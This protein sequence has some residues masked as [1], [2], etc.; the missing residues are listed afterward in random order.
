MNRASL[1][2]STRSGALHRLL[3]PGN[4]TIRVRLS[5]SA[6]Q[7][8][9]K[10]LNSTQSGYKVLE[11]KRRQGQKLDATAITQMIQWLRFIGYSVD[12]SI[13]PSD[14]NRMNIIHV[15]GTKGKG[16]T[17]AYTNS[18]LQRFQD[19]VHVPRKIGL[20]TSPHLVAVRERIRINSEPISEE[21][22][23]KYF[24]EVW[25]GLEASASK[26]GLDPGHKPS[27][28]RFLTLMSFHVFMRENVDAAIYEV[29]VGGEYDSTNIVDKPAAVAI[30]TLG[31]DHVQSLGETIDLIAWHKAGIM[32]TGSPAVTTE[33][34][35][36]AMEVLEK[37]AEEKGVRLSK[38]IPS[39]AL[40]R[41]SLLPAQ[42]FQRKNAS[43]AVELAYTVLDKLNVPVKRSDDSLPTQFVEGL[44]TLVWRGRCET[45]VTGKQHWYMDGAHNEQSLEVACQWFGSVT[46]ASNRPRVL[47]FNQQS[48]RESHQ[49]L[50]GIH[51]TIYKD[52]QTN[53]QYAI[54]CTNITY[55][56]QSWNVD[57]A[58]HNVD[59][60]ELKS[61]KL[62]HEMAETW[63]RLD[64][65]AEAVAVPTI[66]DAIEFIR[67]LDG[68]ES[69]IDV[70]VTGSFHLVGGALTLLEGKGFA[71]K[72]ISSIL[73]S[74][75]A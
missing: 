25:N 53:F 57:H 67:K 2:A 59:P 20:Y 13:Q 49:L 60:A 42:D 35:P 18:I 17:C 6:Y 31:I 9:V 63:R 48:T 8:A 69:E 28:F 38:V 71:L 61:M 37:R 3:Q 73:Q 62:Q 33:Q 36:E 64:P 47:I 65:S 30:T 74:D 40:K 7:D 55:K 56:D 34:I 50:E 15:A 46:K 70:L 54:F 52:C 72:R 24:F 51:Q 32:K 66:E 1:R 26:E 41:V 22:F 11:E 43:L 19:T 23:A 5:T 39:P 21:L 27:Y 14:L 4:M 45:K 44:E 12:L 75:S 29:G 68:G 16:T 10:L 58:N